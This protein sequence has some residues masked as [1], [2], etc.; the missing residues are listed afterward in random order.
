MK[1]RFSLHIHDGQSGILE[2]LTVM[3]NGFIGSH[4]SGLV[5]VTNMPHAEN[6]HPILP[7]TIFNVQSSGESNVRFSSL[8][9][10]KSS[11]EL[12]G[13]GNSKASGLHISYS[14][15]ESTVDFSLLRASGC[16]GVESGFMTVTSNGLIAIGTTKVNATR[17]FSAN[18]PL[19]IWHNG[20]TNSGTI[21][22]KEQ[23][24]A[25]TNTSDFGKIY[26]KPDPVLD[27]DN[28]PAVALSAGITIGECQ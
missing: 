10:E 3:R 26:V 8:S 2:A 19:T 17:L 9:L 24:S 25:P 15:S 5:G 6:A 1:D 21:A 16:G 12:L 13:N 20:T 4:P 23:A 7:E 11:L 22:L 14:P 18:S 27:G 28:T